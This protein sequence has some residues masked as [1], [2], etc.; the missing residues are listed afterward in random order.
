MRK[1]RKVVFVILVIIVLSGIFHCYSAFKEVGVSNAHLCFV[2]ATIIS[3]NKNERELTVELCNQ[4]ELYEEKI[5]I[6]KCD[7]YKNLNLVKGDKIEYSVFP[8]AINRVFDLTVI[9]HEEYHYR[10][11]SGKGMGGR[12]IYTLVICLTEVYRV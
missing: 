11:V 7:E 5:V 3:V 10:F 1:S 8:G 2:E 6:L 4:F 9:P 12:V